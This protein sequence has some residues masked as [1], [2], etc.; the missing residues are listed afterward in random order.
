MS[1]AGFV[2]PTRKSG[3]LYHIE[4]VEE[5]STTSGLQMNMPMFCC[6]SRGRFYYI[7]Q[8][9]FNGI[10]QGSG[11]GVEQVSPYQEKVGSTASALQPDISRKGLFSPMKKTFGADEYIKRCIM[12][13]K[14]DLQHQDSNKDCSALSSQVLN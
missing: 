6:W 2:S 14:S 7:P 10:C 11:A 4:G 8:L 12:K 5:G 3:E 1:R 9:D 13:K